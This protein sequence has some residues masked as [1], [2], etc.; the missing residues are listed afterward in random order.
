MG[1][2]ADWRAVVVREKMLEALKQAMSDMGRILAW[3]E[4]DGE[5]A[6]LHTTEHW[7]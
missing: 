6:F 4:T 2:V 7:H 1:W 3:E 5:I